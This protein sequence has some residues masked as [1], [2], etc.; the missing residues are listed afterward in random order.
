M[1]LRRLTPR[2]QVERGVSKLRRLLGFWRRA[3]V[4]FVVTALVSVPITLNA[5][6][7]Y[8][9]ETVILYQETIRS[10]DVTGTGGDGV[11]DNAR[12]LGARLREALM[13]RA[14]LGRIVRECHL[15]PRLVEQRGFI[16]A[17][18]EMRKHISFRAR[19]GD[20]FEIAFE[21]TSPEEVQEVTRRLAE[22]I[23]QEAADKRAERARALKEFVDVESERNKAELKQKE[24]AL[25]SFL[26]EHPEFKRRAGTDVLASPV[27]API[28]GLS[29]PALEARAALIAQRLA[30]PPA[31]R[32][33]TAPQKTSEAP[34]DSPEVVA[35]RRDLADKLSRYT[36]RHPDVTAARVRLR[37]AEAA[38]AA[39]TDWS[40]FDT[41]SLSSDDNSGRGDAVDEK[42]ALRAQLAAV[43]A[44][45]AA[46]RSQAATG[47]GAKANENPE[48]RAASAAPPAASGTSGSVDIEVEFRRLL[49]EVHDARERQRQLDESQFKASITA[50][51]VMNDRNIQVLVLD[52]AYRPTHPSSRPRSTTLGAALLLCLVLALLTAGVS[53]WL[54]DRIHE[55]EDLEHFDALPLLAVVPRALPAPRRG[56][57]HG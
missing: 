1:K 48:P 10:A 24:G 30:A 25:A 5:P 18:D 21:G 39:A 11:F 38:Q 56:S 51:S 6:R 49:R 2:D 16:D 20:T 33:A 15:Y 35:A 19:E 12:R 29:L 52:P 46:R 50:S 14:S 43:N 55:R 40:A 36:E 53:T 37:S 22:S 32:S 13:S 45:I 17:V 4:V 57:D 9:S 31:G 34:P 42:E 27:A 26:A 23:V 41:P 3:L 54:D 8:K 47:A 28:E 44:Q 7:S